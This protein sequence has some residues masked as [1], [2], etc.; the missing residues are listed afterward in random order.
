MIQ[1][2]RKPGIVQTRCKCGQPVMAR[3]ER[4]CL[5]CH[6]AYMREWR[7]DNPLNDEQ[8][9]KDIARSKVSVYVRRGKIQKTPCACCGSVEVKA[10]ILDYA[11]PL[12]SVEWLCAASHAYSV[13]TGSLPARTRAA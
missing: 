1:A 12:H 10:R 2:K 6:A 4:H 8:K 3:N 11:D 5:E 9:R 13:R 7:K